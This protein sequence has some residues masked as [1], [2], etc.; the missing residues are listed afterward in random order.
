M[1]HLR[2]Y[3]TPRTIIVAIVA[4]LLVAL[5]VLLGPLA[6][7]GPRIVAVTPENG[8]DDANPQAPI[9][10]EFDQWV[11][12]D[13]V[14][15]VA[16]I[17]PATEFAV[18]QDGSPRPWGSAVLIQP[19]SPLRY[20]AR[21]HLTIN[22]QLG[23]ILGRPLIEPLAIAFNTAPYVT[24]ASF[25]PAQDA[26]DVPLNAPLTV[27]FGAPVVPTEQIA[28]AAQDSALADS[29]P[30]P[31]T[32]APET[33]G[34]GRWLSPTLYGFYPEGGLRAATEYNVTIPAS[35]TPDGKARLEKEVAWRFTTAAP[36]LVG[37]RPFDGATEAPASGP[38][39]VRLAPDVDVESAGSHFAL[40][41]AATGAPV[42]GTITKSSGGFLFAPTQPLQ[43]GA[44]YEA[45]LMSGITTT[46]GRPLNADPLSWTFTVIGDLE[47]AQ[48]E[49]PPDTT[50]V[51]AS[52]RRISVRFNHPVVALTTI[53][54]QN[55]APP[56]KIDPPVQGV[57]RWLDTSTYVFNPKAGLA[58]STG[59]SVRV[60]AGLQDQTGGALRQE[61]SWG[62]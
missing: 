20:G 4:L 9:R 49:P 55:S 50:E 11:S 58:P 7:S 22:S 44:R 23:N 32:L 35:I 10:V 53:E 41:D 37:V 60:A 5:G 3:L 40:V 14:A 38:V 21:Y 12:A 34:V 29:L 25:G 19:R 15:R 6:L 31:L 39:E 56:F 24:V 13:A 54:G 36:L 2:Q 28:A 16:V 18:T 33:R 57:G 46:A 52:A 30:R 42:A 47:V 45:R 43:R 61:Y 1:K 48:V 59:Y 62:F 8:A 51:L 26:R 17:D 27:E